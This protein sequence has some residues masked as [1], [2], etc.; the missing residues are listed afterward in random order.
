MESYQSFAQVYDLFMDNVD[1]PAW[2]AYLTG[3]LRK[4]GITDG[5]VLDLGCGTGSMTECLA[6]AGYEMI[7]VDASLEMLEA[8][9]EKKIESGLDILYLQQ[10]MR[11]FELYGTV[12][13]VVSCCDSLN[14]ILDPRELQEIFRLV[15]NYLDPG[16]IFLFDMNTDAKYRAIGDATIAENRDEGSFIWENTYDESSRINEYALTL[17]LPVEEEEDDNVPPRFFERCQETHYQRAYDPEEIRRLLEEAGLECLA[18][19]D[20]FTEEAAGPESERICFMAREIH[21]K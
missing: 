19:L 11:S 6:R 17:F 15:N 18:I 14:Y 10:D 13:A 9:Q 7:G 3:L 1:Y 21:K 12:R 4:Q 5:L 2:C 8:A 16:G 20:C